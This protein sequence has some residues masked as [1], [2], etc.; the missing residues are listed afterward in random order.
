VR[1]RVMDA[2]LAKMGGGVETMTFD[3]VLAG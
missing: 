2:V 3:E 1:D